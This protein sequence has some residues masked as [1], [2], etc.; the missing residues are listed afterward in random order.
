M[1]KLTYFLQSAALVL[2]LIS[3]RGNSNRNTNYENYSSQD[4]YID[5]AEDG[6][7]DGTYCATIDYYYFKTGTN[8]TYTLE[9]EIENNELTVIH[10]PNGGWLDDSHFSP[11]D[12]SDGEASF[13]SDRGMDYT[14]R[15][16]GSEGDCN[17]DTYVVDE[18][19]LIRQS[20]EEESL[21]QEDDAERLQQD[22]DERLQ[23]DE[24]ERLQKEEE[25]G[26]QQEEEEGSNQDDDN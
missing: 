9:V 15:I 4:E 17:L 25:E 10:W 7:T 26:L 8:S 12:I 13:K 6:Y 1:M 5:D 20:E 14:V 11:P 16:I 18:D 23:Q 21:Q 22:E 24:D 2:I 19:E 3:C